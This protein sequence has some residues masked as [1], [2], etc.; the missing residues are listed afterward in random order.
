MPGLSRRDQSAT[1]KR[2]SYA[3]IA[4]TVCTLAPRWS[5]TSLGSLDQYVLV[6]ALGRFELDQRRA[7]LRRLAAIVIGGGPA[8]LYCFARLRFCC[9]RRNSLNRAS[10]SAARAFVAERPD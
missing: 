7:N 6:L 8:L 1:S 4:A 10:R 2:I 3:R 5:T 9:H